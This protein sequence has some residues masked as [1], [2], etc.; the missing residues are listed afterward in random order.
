MT[1]VGWLFIIM[2]PIALLYELYLRLKAQKA[3]AWPQVDGEITHSEVETVCSGGSGGRV[4]F[5]ADIKYKY[6]VGRRTYKNDKVC[7]GN[8]TVSVNN[9]SEAQYKC[10]DYPIG[11]TV[12]VF[13]NPRKPTEACLEPR[14]ETTPGILTLSIAFFI[15]GVFAVNGIFE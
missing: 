11:K 1:F 12:K 14:V 13:H 3:K 15:I 6:K 8:V 5:R 7:V 2:A 4:T 9:K 10:R